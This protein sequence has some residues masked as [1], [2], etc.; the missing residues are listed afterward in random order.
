M[1]GSDFAACPISRLSWFRLAAYLQRLEGV[2]ISVTVQDDVVG[3]AEALSD[4]QVVE[5]GGLP[6]GIGH[7]H[8]SYVW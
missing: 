3:H 8:H 4:A 1:N 6:E 2:G 7:L 5:E